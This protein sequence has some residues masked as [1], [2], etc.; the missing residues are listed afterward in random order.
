MTIAGHRNHRR[1]GDAAQS[2]FALGAGAIAKAAIRR[3]VD[4]PG[5]PIQHVDSVVALSIAFFINAAILV[6]AAMVFFGR[7]RRRLVRRHR[8]R[9]GRLDSDRLSDACRRCSARLRPACC[10]PIALLASG[11]SSTITG[12]LAG[13]VVMEGFMHWRIRPWLRRLITRSLAIAPAV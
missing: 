9:A 13:Q 10:S 5:D 6:L 7:S 2:V 11:Q 4:P 12:T 3:S 8:H 1:H